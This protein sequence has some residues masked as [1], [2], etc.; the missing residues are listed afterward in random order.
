MPSVDLALLC[1]SATISNGLISILDGGLDLVETSVLPFRWMS[2]FLFRISWDDNELGEAHVIRVVFEH[3]DGEQLANL[4]AGAIP[5]RTSSNA[6]DLLVTTP[7][8][9]PL[10][11]EF[12]R[13]GRYWIR[14]L[15][16][17][18]ELKRLPFTVALTHPQL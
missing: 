13:A 10:P 7:A 5:E 15:V 11:L 3:T 9:L 12:R 4:D 2:T 14:V 18:D 1:H 16:D 17:G 6:P 8:I